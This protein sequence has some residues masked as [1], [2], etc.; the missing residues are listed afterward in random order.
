[1]KLLNRK[2]ALN[3]CTVAIF[4]WVYRFGWTKGTYH[5]HDIP[6]KSWSSLDHSNSKH[7]KKKKKKKNYIQLFLQKKGSTL[8][9]NE[10]Q[11]TDATVVATLR[12]DWRDGDLLALFSGLLKNR[13]HC[14]KF[15]DFLIHP[16]V[17]VAKTLP[18]WRKLTHSELVPVYCR[19][20]SCWDIP[21]YFCCN[22]SLSAW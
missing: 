18:G 21:I 9:P 7:P 20:K 16:N 3:T 17:Y 22:S 6:N 19:F 15:D 2:I 10:S 4:N 12:F 14:Q 11:I 1:M 8:A 5:F 13:R